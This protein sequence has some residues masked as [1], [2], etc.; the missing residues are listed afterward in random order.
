MFD[1]KK[2]GKKNT[3]ALEKYLFFVIKFALVRKKKKKKVEKFFGKY[4]RRS[5]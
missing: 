1:V 2:K 4:Q 5:V 3:K